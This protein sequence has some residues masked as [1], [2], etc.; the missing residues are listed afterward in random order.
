MKLKFSKIMSLI[1]W[2]I[3]DWYEVYPFAS[4][5]MCIIHQIRAR[6]VIFIGVLKKAE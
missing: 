1:F 4:I 5:Q 6:N 3:S 2:N